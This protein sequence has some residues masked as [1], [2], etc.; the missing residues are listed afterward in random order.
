MRSVVS[1]NSFIEMKQDICVDYYSYHY[2]FEDEIAECITPCNRPITVSDIIKE[3]K[4][5]WNLSVIEK[6]D[7]SYNYIS[8]NGFRFIFQPYTDL[9]YRVQ[10]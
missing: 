9:A 3:I 8:N 4:S 2:I 6:L 7:L 10:L 1:T 5:N